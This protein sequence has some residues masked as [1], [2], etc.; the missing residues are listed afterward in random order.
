MSVC[1]L[2]G[3]AVV[4]VGPYGIT[5]DN[6]VAKRDG[7]SYALQAHGEVWGDPLEVRTSSTQRHCFSHDP[8]LASALTLTSCCTQVTSLRREDVAFVAPKNKTFDI[9]QGNTLPSSGTPRGHQVRR[10]ALP[11][12]GAS[13]FG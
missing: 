13:S 2:T 3:H 10:L 12:T 4:S 5:L 6:S 9:L 1:T 8:S 11:T 7:Q